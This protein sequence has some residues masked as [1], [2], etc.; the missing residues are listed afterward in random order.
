MHELFLCKYHKAFHHTREL[1]EC[2]NIKE[3]KPKKIED[4]RKINVNELEGF[5]EVRGPE[6]SDSIPE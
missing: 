3:G 5:K 1:A 4:L 6:L 2:Y